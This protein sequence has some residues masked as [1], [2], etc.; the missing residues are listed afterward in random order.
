MTVIYAEID[1]KSKEI[2]NVLTDK[3]MRIMLKEEI[4]V[5]SELKEMN[6]VYDHNTNLYKPETLH[7][8]LFRAKNLFED[9]MFLE[10]FGQFKQKFKKV[11]F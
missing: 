7:I 1:K 8:S 6:I 10:M 9:E 4:V 2:L 5:A 3:L 11:G